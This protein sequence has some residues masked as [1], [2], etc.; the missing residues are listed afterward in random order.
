M[1]MNKNIIWRPTRGDLVKVRYLGVFGTETQFGIVMGEKFNDENTMFPCIV[2]HIFG[3][4]DSQRC[5]PHQLEILSSA[6]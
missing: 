4:N 3:L 6:N 1:T 2:V 5:M